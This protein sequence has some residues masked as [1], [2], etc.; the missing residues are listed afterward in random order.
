MKP[1]PP[2][3]ITFSQEPLPSGLPPAGQ[4]N[5]GL[6]WGPPILIAQKYLLPT[7]LLAKQKCPFKVCEKAGGGEG[8][9]LPI[10]PVRQKAKASRRNNRR[11]PAVRL[12][13]GVLCSREG[14]LSEVCVCSVCALVCSVCAQCLCRV[15]ECLCVFLCVCSVCS[16]HTL[17]VPCVFSCVCVCPVWCAL[18]CCVCMCGLVCVRSYVCAVCA[19]PV[20]ALVCVQCVCVQCVSCMCC[21]CALVCLCIVCVCC[22]CVWLQP[23]CSG[24]RPCWSCVQCGSSSYKGC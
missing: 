5:L 7:Y 15:C 21:V 19:C 4:H 1:L 13:T 23:H 8:A 2:H 12:P 9:A 6:N 24:E 20:G 17:S 16:V 14:A 18:V 22:V 10:S 3:H 11:Q